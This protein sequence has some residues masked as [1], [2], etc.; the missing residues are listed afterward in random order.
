MS[1]Y[2]DDYSMSNN[3]LS[4]YESGLLP[5]SK[6]TARALKNA[7]ITI[8]LKQFKELCREGALRPAEWHHT[9]SRYNRTNFY[10]LE[11]CKED[12]EHIDIARYTSQKNKSE[13]YAARCAWVEWSGSRNHPRAHDREGIALIRGEWAIFPTGKKKKVSGNHFR[14]VAK[15]D[16]I[17]EDLAPL[18]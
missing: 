7:G 15:L 1:G 16:T 2:A 12:L 4:A 8:S 6:I 5:L 14:I 3:A 13:S 11:Q 18:I 17:P 9:S 10:D